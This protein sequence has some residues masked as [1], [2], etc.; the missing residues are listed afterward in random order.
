MG[1][2]VDAT[3]WTFAIPGLVTGIQRR[4][5]S[6]RLAPRDKPG[7]DKKREFIMLP[8]IRSVEYIRMGTRWGD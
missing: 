3:A 2:P 6:Q 7:D 5:P 8:R 4:T 1:M